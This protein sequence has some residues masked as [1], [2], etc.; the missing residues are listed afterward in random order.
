MGLLSGIGLDMLTHDFPPPAFPDALIHSDQF[1]AG[2]SRKIARTEHA[3]FLNLPGLESDPKIEEGRCVIYVRARQIKSPTYPDCA[4]TL[5]EVKAHTSIR[6]KR[7]R[8]VPR[9][10]K[11]VVIEIERRRWMCKS[12]GKTITQPVDFMA[13]G[14]YKMTRRLFEYIEVQSLLGTELS[15]SEETGVFVRTIREIRH[16]FVEKLKVDVTFDSPYVLGMDGVRADGKRRRIIIT[17]VEAG[18]VHDLLESG[19]K[20]SVA[21]RIRRF[22]EWE[23]IGIFTIDMDR[24]LLAAVL[25][26]RP[27]AV[28]VI[29]RFHIVRIANQVMD[30]VRNRLFPREKKKREPGRPYRPRPEPFRKRR[31]NLTG[32]DLEHMA[33]W[34]GERPELRLA[35]DLKESFM[36][37]FDD[38]TYGS[39]HSMSKSAARHFFEAWKRSLPIGKEYAALLKDFRKIL[40]AMSNFGE[41]VLNYFDCLYTN[42]F[43]ESMNRKIRDILRDTRGCD[44]ETVRAR[45]IYGTYLMKQLRAA[46]ESERE[47]VLPHSKRKNSR[48]PN[49]KGKNAKRGKA[50][51]RGRSNSYGLPESKQMALEFPPPTEGDA[52]QGQQG[53]TLS[54][55]G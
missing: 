6:M 8:D 11:T 9:A 41:Y 17:D 18:L 32:K 38:E 30:T 15:L 22:P 39:R 2:A 50:T 14:R 10:R 7:I 44:F 4:C 29:D 36:E 37:I 47:A 20:Q 1:F 12:C 43:T 54:A 46:R 23:K 31:A 51:E 24:T 48:Q 40:T 27:D 34:C 25:D 16:E 13:E 28:I 42:A 45:I 35:Y 3:D 5:K 26:V 53:G 33:Y 55:G 21:E 49:A 52:D 19:S